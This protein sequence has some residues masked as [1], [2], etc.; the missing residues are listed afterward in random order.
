MIKTLTVQ[1]PWQFAKLP[2]VAN[3]TDSN[4]QDPQICSQ[5][6]SLIQTEYSPTLKK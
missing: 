2:V 1:F 4:T 6:V 5:H 3:C